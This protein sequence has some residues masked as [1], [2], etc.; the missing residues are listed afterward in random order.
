MS[1]ITKPDTKYMM[2]MGRPVEDMTKEELIKALFM[3]Y[4]LQEK[5]SKDLLQAKIDWINAL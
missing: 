5:T 4:Q 3:M 2:W 1:S